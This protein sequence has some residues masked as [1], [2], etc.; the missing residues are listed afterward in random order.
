MITIWKTPIVATVD[1][2]ITDLKLQVYGAGLLKDITNTGSD[3]MV[4]C[5]FHKGGHEHKPSCGVSLQEKV[6]RDRKYE[7]GTVH[8]YTCG[9]T[10]ELPQFVSDL[11]GLENRVAGFKWLVGK[12]NYSTAER[13]PIELN[14]YR[15]G[16]TQNS[17]QMELEEVEAYSSALRNSQRPL[18]YLQSRCISTEVMELYQCG[19]DASDDVVLFPV[20]SIK[21]EVLFFKGRSISGKHF[22]NAKDVDKTIAVYGL[23]QL[24]K[25]GISPD[26]EI[27]ITES[28]IDALSLISRGIPAIAIMGSHISEMQISEI[29]KT[30]YRRFVLALDNDE[31][32]KKGSQKIKNLMIKHGCRFFNLFWKTSLKDINELI[33]K[34]GDAYTEYLQRY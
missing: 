34:H 24:I 29:L 26:T 30:P 18:N 17:T 27:W 9:Y 12:Y 33:T 15:G 32:G 31:A 10:A 16:E 25:R 19:Y 4:T 8:C 23:Y 28:E 11:L 6:T 13:D 3:V 21:G 22:Y 7:A 14:I 1:Q 20:Y 2:I 5:P